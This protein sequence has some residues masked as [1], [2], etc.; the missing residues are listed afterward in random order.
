VTSQNITITINGDELYE[1]DE[2]FAINLSNLS[3]VGGIN[4]QKTVTIV[5]DDAK[6]T[7]LISDASVNEGDSGNTPVLFTLTLQQPSALPATVTYSTSSGQAQIGSDFQNAGGTVTFAPGETSKTITV[8]V[9]GDTAVEGDENF[10]VNLSNGVDV[11]IGDNLGLGVIVNDDF[12]P[13]LQV[14]DAEVVE[15]DFGTKSMVFTVTRTGSTANPTTVGY[16]TS[17]GTATAGLDFILNQG[18]LTFGT[19]ETTKT[20]TVLVKGDEIAELDESFFLNLSNP[21]NA[22][23]ADGQGFGQILNDDN[24]PPAVTMPVGPISTTE[25]VNVSIPGISVSD[26]D[27]GQATIQVTLSAAHGTIVVRNNVANGLTGAQILNNGTNEVTLVGSI[28][29]IN[30][31][32]GSSNGV[33][34]RGFTD[35]AGSDSLMVQADDLGNTGNSGIP[36]T[37]TKAVTIVVANVNDAPV[38][39]YTAT[40]GGT[41]DPITSTKGNAV[42]AFGPPNSLTLADADNLNFNGGRITVTNLGPF[43]SGKDKISIRNQGTDPGLIG[44]TKKGKLTYGGQEIGTVSGGNGSNPLVIILNSKA[45]IEATTALMRNITFG[46]KKGGLTAL[47]RTIRMTLTDGSGGT[48]TPPVQ[49][50]INVTN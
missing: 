30:L 18:T 9:N 43:I 38:I 10:F 24:S 36:K 50:V 12:L 44:F 7:V 45:S 31:T 1:R 41:P 37:D 25:E 15:G 13:S 11:V 17:N 28:S 6:P 40:G 29:A 16:S 14:S 2:T 8:N 26:P 23:I 4:T 3:N 33:V 21:S 27:A 49:S 48:S 19:G 39:E 5:N 20:V 22:T 32:L 47:P 35:F 42:A 34:Y 46:T